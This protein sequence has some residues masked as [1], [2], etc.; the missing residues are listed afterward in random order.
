MN[1]V[2]LV[3]LHRDTFSDLFSCGIRFECQLFGLDYYI[4]YYYF[5]LLFYIS[6]KN[7]TVYICFHIF[8]LIL[9]LS[10]LVAAG[11]NSVLEF[12]LK[13]VGRLNLICY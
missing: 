9:W 12:E 6:K 5:V 2:V 13:K 8:S 1:Y 11:Y 10:L 7:V 3:C 4:L